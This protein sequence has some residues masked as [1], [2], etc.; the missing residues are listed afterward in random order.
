L[1]FTD[2]PLLSFTEPTVTFPLALL[3]LLEEV[4]GA[5]FWHA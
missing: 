5:S 2:P 1:N 3:L 4:V